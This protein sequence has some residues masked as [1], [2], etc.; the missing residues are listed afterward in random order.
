MS[1][2][3]SPLKSVASHPLSGFIA[4]PGDKSISHR[5]IILG[6]LTIGQSVVSHLLESTDV[7]DTVKAMVALGAEISRSNDGDY[8]INGVGVGGLAEPDN[9]IDCGN[10]GTSVR[11]IMGCQS[12]KPT[13][14]TCSKTT[15]IIWCK[16]YFKVGRSFTNYY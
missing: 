2:S 9:V 7:L 4:V 12:E 10:S 16:L 15:F 1:G 3:I 6:S 11:L 8:I 5:A 14:V 13:N